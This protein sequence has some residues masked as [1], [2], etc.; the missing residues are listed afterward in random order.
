MGLEGRRGTV[1][2]EGGSLGVGVE[3]WGQRGVNWGIR[4]K[5]VSIS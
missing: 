5:I 4:A 1:G 3:A 2:S